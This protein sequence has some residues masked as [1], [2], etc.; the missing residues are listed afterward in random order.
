[1]PDMPVYAAGMGP[2]SQRNDA[3]IAGAIGGRYDEA[4]RPV[5]PVA[6]SR[7]ARLFSAKPGL[8]FVGKANSCS[9]KWEAWVG[10]R[11]ITDARH[12]DYEVFLTYLEAIFLRGSSL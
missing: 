12:E 11:E 7:A 4:P 6:P 1:M 2:Y 10:D 5:M 8:R 9:K 3:S